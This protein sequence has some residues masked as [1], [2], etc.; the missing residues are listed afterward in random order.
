MNRTWHAYHAIGAT[1]VAATLALHYAPGSF[2][3]DTPAE[4]LFSFD[5]DEIGKPPDAFLEALTAGGGP[6]K[7]HVI[8]A[9]DAPSGK[10]VVA[11][12]S[13]D[14]TNNRYPLLVLK[15]F[16]AKDVDVSV[17]FKP[18]LGGLDQAAGIVWRWQD[19]NNYLVARANALENNVVAYKTVA[20]KRT[21]IGVKGNSKAYGVNTDVPA[22][23]WSTL[24]VRM[25]GNLAQIHLNK[26]KLFEVESDVITSAGKVGLWTKADSVTYFDDLRV[27]S[28][29]RK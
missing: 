22:N 28:L 12:L 13:E 7:W 29:D 25:V 11:Q 6:A 1:L 26:K 15:E 17:R 14:A 24:R 4:R 23:E 10:H 20:G 19:K 16:S 9:D 18:V 2:A 21:S 27:T 3:G 5:R 8:D